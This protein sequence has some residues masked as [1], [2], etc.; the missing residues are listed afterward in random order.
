M[1]DTSNEDSHFA[2]QINKRPTEI[3]FNWLRARSYDSD[4]VPN[5]R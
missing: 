3:A 1:Q 5:P 2:L 4:N